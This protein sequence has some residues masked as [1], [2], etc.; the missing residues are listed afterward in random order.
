MATNPSIP[1]QSTSAA[2]P[3]PPAPQVSPVPPPQT[4]SEAQVQAVRT[5][6]AGRK[7]IDL[8]IHVATFNGW[9]LAI[10]AVLSGLA[11]LLSFGLLGAVVTAGLAATAYYE[12]KGRAMLRQLDPHGARHLGYN[13]L[14]LGVLIVVYCGWS[15][16]NMFFGPGSYDQVIAR[17]PELA[18]VL[19]NSEQMIRVLAVAVY[20]VVILLAVPY[21]IL[22]AWFYFSRGK[23]IEQYVESTPAW[24]TQ[25]QQAAA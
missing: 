18:D 17:N 14:A 20:G 23:L 6:K 3:V 13:Q 2:P 8:A 19:G 15:M 24:I 7:K 9:S 25:V 5:A 10:F 4:L 12:F 11:W 22:I 21:Q 1:T 16:I